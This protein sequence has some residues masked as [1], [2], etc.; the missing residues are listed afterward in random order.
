MPSLYKIEFFMGFNDKYE[1]PV[2]YQFM[3]ITKTDS[4]VSCL[5][6]GRVKVLVLPLSEFPENE[7]E[8][9]LEKLMNYQQID[10]SK[11]NSKEGSEGIILLE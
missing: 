10:L 5:D 1:H 6:S 9:Y 2:T 11:L 3:K 4:V 7:W 8:K